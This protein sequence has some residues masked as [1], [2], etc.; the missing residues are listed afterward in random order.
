MCNPT[1]VS[2][3]TTFNVTS[4]S[5]GVIVWTPW[6]LAVGVNNLRI[7]RNVQG[8][9]GSPSTN[10]VYQ[11]AAVKTTEPDAWTG[12]GTARTGDGYD[13]DNVDISGTTNKMWVRAGMTASATT[14]GE[15]EATITLMT[16]SEAK[17]IGTKTINMVATRGT[18]ASVVKLSEPLPIVGM[19]K[20][21]CSVIY[22]HEGGSTDIQV[23]YRKIQDD[24]DAGGGWTSLAS[25]T[26]WATDQNYNTTEVTLSDDTTYGYFQPAMLYK[27]TTNGGTMK[28]IFVALW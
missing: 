16:D 2:K 9:S 4:S 17:V 7:I 5:A 24:L 6:T 3:T 19:S 13:T 23:S 15:G 25:Q 10:Y 27:N 8:S 20:V 18:T 11:Y 12:G 1:N 21:F 28:V 22:S 14:Q 26:G